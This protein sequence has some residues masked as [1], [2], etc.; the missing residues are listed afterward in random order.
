ME[1][2]IYGGMWV[3]NVWWAAENRGG[4]WRRVCLPSL[5]LVSYIDTLSSCPDPLGSCNFNETD[6]KGFFF[7]PSLHLTFF[8][9]ATR[10]H[11]Y[12]TLEKKKKKNPSFPHCNLVRAW[13]RFSFISDTVPNYEKIAHQI[14]RPTRLASRRKRGEVKNLRER[15]SDT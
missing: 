12:S 2:V 13:H 5:L 10:E 7:F 4:W 6:S 11:H 3:R 8:F 9:S 1:A 15:V 14:K